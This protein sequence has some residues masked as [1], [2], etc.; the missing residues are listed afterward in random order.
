MKTITRSAVLA[1]LTLLAVPARGDDGMFDPMDSGSYR[2][3]KSI[4]ALNWEIAQPVGDF[5]NYI[6][7]TSLSGFSLES[8]SMV[9]RNV[10]AGI[11][12]SYNRFDQTYPSLQQTSGTVTVTGPVF[13]YTDMFGIRALGHFYFLEGKVVQPYIGG[14]IGGVW[15]YG[16]QQIADFANSESS[17]NFIISPE[18]GVLIQLARGATNLGLNLAVRYTYT[19]AAVGSTK[20]DQ[21]FSGIAG[22]MWSY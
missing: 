7:R 15:A 12:F 4:W 2:P 11:S 8:R 14:G 17:F 3:D 19:T 10:S 6:D 16:Y 9:R 18:A 5:S 20:N 1:L 13:R 22:F 21:T